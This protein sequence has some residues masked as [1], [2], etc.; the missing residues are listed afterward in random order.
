MFHCIEELTDIQIQHPVYLSLHNRN[1]QG[2]QCIML[3][4]SRSESV[5]KPQKISLVD[6][7]QHG[8]YCLLHDFVF[9]TQYTQRPF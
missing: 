6:L 8:H 4:L 3:T 1:I 2:I 7:I 9:Q 5:G